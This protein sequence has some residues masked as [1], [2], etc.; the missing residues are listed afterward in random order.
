[1]PSGMGGVLQTVLEGDRVALRPFTLEDVQLVYDACQDEE[2]HRWT[3]TLPRPYTE[4]DPQAWIESH[5]SRRRSGS[6]YDFAVVEAG[7]RSFCGSTD[8]RDGRGRARG[9]PSIGAVVHCPGCGAAVSEWAARC[10]D[11]DAPVADAPLIDR[12]EPPQRPTARPRSRAGPVV[13]TILVVALAVAVMRFDDSAPAGRSTTTMSAPGAGPRSSVAIT[14]GPRRGWLAYRGDAGRLRIVSLGDGASVVPDGTVDAYPSR[15]FVVGGSFI[16]T[17][18][19]MAWAVTP[20]KTVTTRRRL[21]PADGV[22]PSEDPEALWVIRGDPAF[23]SEVQLVGVDGKPRRETVRLPPGGRLVAAVGGSLVLQRVDDQVLELYDLQRLRVL[24]FLGQPGEVIDSHGVMLVWMAV[25]HGDCVVG[26][27]LHVTDA[28]TGEDRV[29]EPPDGMGWVRA[30]AI[31][32]DGRRLAAFAASRTE[33]VRRPGASG[34]SLV[35]VDLVT[36]EETPIQDSE[37]P[38]GEPVIAAA[39]S[40]TS[41]WVFFAGLGGPMRAYFPGSRSAVQLPWPASYTFAVT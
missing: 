34:A 21:A 40:E 24:P 16:F 22:V 18:D 1:M 20:D 9:I 38:Y 12:P 36:V 26:C 10:P 4:Q 33:G 17:D 31:S 15:T 27:R 8:R 13:L 39:W 11:C 32:A 2:I 23:R 29:V 6:S 28:A 30:G 5:P 37:V 3:V 7:A 19:G 14:A 41:D 35:V 25:P